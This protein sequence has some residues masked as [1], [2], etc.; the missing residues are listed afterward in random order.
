MESTTAEREWIVCANGFLLTT[1]GLMYP[2]I[3]T[4]ES[5]IV[6]FNSGALGIGEDEI[7]LTIGVFRVGPPP[8]RV[9]DSPRVD[10][11]LVVEFTLPPMGNVWAWVG[12]RTPTLRGCR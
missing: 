12:S 11:R 6:I 7:P 10:A 1:E 2:D 3:V 8:A 4:S 5:V 9:P